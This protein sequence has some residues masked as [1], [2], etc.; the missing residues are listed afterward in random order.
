MF[1]D[2]EIMIMIKKNV[3]WWGLLFKRQGPG[4]EL[5]SS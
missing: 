3:W 4:F 2:L 5:E 1:S